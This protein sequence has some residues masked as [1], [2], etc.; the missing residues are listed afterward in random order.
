MNRIPIVSVA[1]AGLL[2]WCV[3]CAQS[4][5][6]A[7]MK[8]AVDELRMMRQ[9]MAQ[10]GSPDSAEYE[11][12]AALTAF[13]SYMLKKDAQVPYH[14]P[15]IETVGDTERIRRYSYMTPDTF[16]RDVHYNGD[17]FDYIEIQDL[18]IMA[19]DLDARASFKIVPHERVT[20]TVDG[21]QRSALRPIVI[22]KKRVV[23]YPPKSP[24]RLKKL[25]AEKAEKL[26]WKVNYRDAF[27]A[28]FSLP[29]QKKPG[30]LEKL[31]DGITGALGLAEATDD[32]DL[33]KDEKK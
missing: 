15:A 31:G 30:L 22:N 11:I 3:G 12:R 7:Q 33:A 28:G 19:Y 8:N 1:L 29:E 24:V 21:E 26:D 20:V 14:I 32:T 27:I 2:T 16:I 5:E 13:Y 4:P 10:M 25:P 17:R 23:L 6:K 9:E 18:K